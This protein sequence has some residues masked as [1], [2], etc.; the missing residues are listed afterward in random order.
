MAF[1]ISGG[2]LARTAANGR[3]MQPAI[4]ALRLSDNLSVDYWEMWRRQPQIRTVVGFLARNIAQLSLH[5]YRRV[6]DT[7][8]QRTTDHP[9]AQLL[10]RPNPFTTQYRFMESLVSDMAIY[11]NAVIAKVKIAGQPRALLRLDPRRIQLLGDNP[12]RADHYKIMGWDSGIAPQI[13]PA[14]NVIHLRGYSPG[15]ERW[16]TSMLE[17]L[18]VL[19]AEEHQASLYRE[20]LW[21]NGARAAGYLERPLEAPEWSP[22]GK[23]K[24]RAQWQAQ[25]TGDGA[26]AGGTPILEDGMKYVPASTSPRDAQYIEARKLTREEITAAYHIPLTLVGILDNATYSNISEQ[27]KIMYQDTLGPWLTM[28]QQELELQL[29]PE[30]ADVTDLYI[31]FNLAEKLNGSFEQQAAQLQTAVGAP[32]MTRNEA[33]ARVNLPQVD[34]G[35]ELIT[36]LNV[37]EGGQASPTDSA[38]PPA[39]D[40]VA[41]KSAPRALLRAVEGD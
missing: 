32:W 34:G 11:D 10:A 14:E 40:E 31:E 37:L 13:L 24:F 27:H 9:L 22:R 23:E 39:L 5:T 8:R 38:P 17:T 30:F 29:V 16:G 20:Q 3:L 26:S 33:R 6:S 7:D 36:P 25:Y 18:R 12:F 4:T 2:A 15:N 21:R 28:I 1:A 19:L 41:P 35:D